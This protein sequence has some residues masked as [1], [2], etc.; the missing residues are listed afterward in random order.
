MDSKY[1]IVLYGGGSDILDIDYESFDSLQDG[2]TILF[3]PSAKSTFDKQQEYF[4][5]FKQYVSQFGS[6]NVIK[7]DLSKKNL[8]IDYEVISKVGL[9]YLGGGN[10]FFLNNLI[11]K[12][13]FQLFLKRFKNITI[14]GYSAGAAVMGQNIYP[15]SYIDKEIFGVSEQGLHLLPWSIF[16]HYTDSDEQNI[17]LSN[18]AKSKAITIIALPNNCGLVYSDNNYKIIGQ[19]EIKMFLPNGEKTYLIN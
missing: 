18:C 8:E 10:T 4:E 6:F 11:K 12:S 7:F 9:I 5:F 19:N 3:S 1:K 13:E 16:P 15:V 2:A 14:A 17:F